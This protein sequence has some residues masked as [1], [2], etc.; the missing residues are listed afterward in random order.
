MV[1]LDA[2]RYDI[3]EKMYE[4]EVMIRNINNSE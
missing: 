1:N 3:N 2:L 4:V